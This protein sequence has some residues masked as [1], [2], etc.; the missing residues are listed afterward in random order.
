MIK[1]H[2]F[3]RYDELPPSSERLLVV[4][5]WDTASKGG[6][7]NDFSVCTTWI[8]AR[9]V[10]FYLADVWRDR[11]DHPALKAQVMH[12]A[13]AWR[14]RRVL[15]EEAG[16]GISLVQELVRCVRGIIAV[17]PDRDKVS[18]MAVA[19]AKIE[20]GQVFLP[21][22]APWLA[23][24][25]SELFAFPY[26]R[27]DDQCDSISQAL[28]DEGI[29]TALWMTKENLLEMRRRVSMLPRRRFH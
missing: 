9:G 17:R 26:G 25:E 15:I 20:A 8:V 21:D 27:H 11:V 7:E 1:S 3:K 18:R 14:A 16:S 19:S 10:R 6:P 28:N 2:W 24:L 5:S 4:Q 13:M 23:D 22:R 12:Q 29:A